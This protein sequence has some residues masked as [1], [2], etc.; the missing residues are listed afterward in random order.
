[1]CLNNCLFTGQSK[2]FGIKNQRQKGAIKATRRTQNRIDK[3]SS[4]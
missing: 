4:C 2:M 3:S 1:M